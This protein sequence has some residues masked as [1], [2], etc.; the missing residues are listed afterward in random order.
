M[1]RFPRLP[2][3]REA[4][5]YAESLATLLTAS[6]LMQTAPPAIAEAYIATRLSGA[7][8]RMAGAIGAVDE[9]A[10]LARFGPGAG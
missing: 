2:D 6:V 10:I 1:E 8:G 4:R 5:W 7:R 3:P 9:A